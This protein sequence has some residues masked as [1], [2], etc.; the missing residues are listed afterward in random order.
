MKTFSMLLL[1]LFLAGTPLSPTAQAG[2]PVQFR[3]VCQKCGDDLLAV[4]QPVA[5]LGGGYE[6]R[7]VPICH[8]HCRPAALRPKKRDFFHSHLMN[9]ANPKRG[10]QRKLC[11]EPVHFIRTAGPCGQ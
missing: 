10:K 8:Q 1:L 6:Y 4:W 5:C 7:W 2:T 11:A 9:P 3:G